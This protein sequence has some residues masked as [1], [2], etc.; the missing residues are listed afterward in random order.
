MQYMDNWE[1]WRLILSIAKAGSMAQAARDLDIDYSTVFRRLKA[2]ESQLQAR[3]FERT[4]ARCTPTAAGARIIQAAEQAREAF[5]GALLDIAGI[6]TRLTGPIRFTTIPSLADWVLMPMLKDFIQQYPHIQVELVEAMAR[7]NL[8]Q[9]EADIALRITRQPPENLVGQCLGE[10]YSA[11]YASA[12][13]LRQHPEA[14]LHDLHWI[15]PTADLV[16]RVE[17]DWLQ[18]HVS[19]D[20]ISLVAN[21]GLA[22]RQAALNDMGA[23]LLVCYLGDSAGLVR[24]SPPIEEMSS[25]LWL[26]THPSIRQVA[27]IRAFMQ[28]FRERLKQALPMLQGQASLTELRI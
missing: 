27:R 18:A 8:T 24:I 15:M 1:D 4:R 22:G 11:V 13:Y 20:R 25:A 17:L 14:G 10:V 2:L 23:V 7:F 12:D 28:F 26:L 6:D 5:D 3:L 9:R 16:S 21:T 19:E